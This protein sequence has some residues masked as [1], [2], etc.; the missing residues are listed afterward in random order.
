MT[1]KK[2]LE[3]QF[4]DRKQFEF[5]MTDPDKIKALHFKMPGRQPL[6]RFTKCTDKNCISHKRTCQYCGFKFER[7]FE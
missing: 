7:D 6:G 5:S 2:R 4:D 3:V 1:L